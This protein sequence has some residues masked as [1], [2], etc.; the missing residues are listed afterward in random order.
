MA[1]VAMWLIMLPAAAVYAL[2]TWITGRLWP[3]EPE[4]SGLS[5]DDLF[6]DDEAWLSDLAGALQSR[7]D[8]STRRVRQ[9][10]TDARQ[11]AAQSESKLVE[12]FGPAEVYAQRF[13]RSPHKELSR[14]W[15]YGA[16]VL[17]DIVYVTA[18]WLGYMGHGAFSNSFGFA[19]LAANI[20]S[21]ASVIV[22]W[23]RQRSRQRQKDH[24]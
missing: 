3:P 14:V 7:G 6:A 2:V 13:P 22:Q 9:I 21:L 16:I 11:Y 8:I 15:L 5:A 23:R 1:R 12:E 18:L 20:A 4:L 24:S 19:L 10:C 17:V